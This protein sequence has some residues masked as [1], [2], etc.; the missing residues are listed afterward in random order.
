MA[1]FIGPRMCIFATRFCTFMPK[2][3]IPK[4]AMIRL[5]PLW[6]NI[7]S[8]G[9]KRYALNSQRS[10]L[11]NASKISFQLALEACI[12]ANL[13]RKFLNN[14]PDPEKCLKRNAKTHFEQGG[15]KSDVFGSWKCFV[16]SWRNIAN[17][18]T[19]PHATER[20]LTQLSDAYKMSS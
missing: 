15:F 18:A 11:F 4:K 17:W 3:F 14:F 9:T 6:R 7:T 8:C 10:Q 2:Y 13:Y 16:I 12:K 19:K 1:T 20:A 5:A